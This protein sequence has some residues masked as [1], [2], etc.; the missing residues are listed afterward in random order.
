MFVLIFNQLLKMLFIMLLAVICFKIGLINQ[1]GNR[2]L[3]NLLLMVINPCVILTVYQTD[4]D[5]R[6]ARGLLISFAAAFAAHIIAIAVARL[7]IPSKNNEN[8]AIDRF[9]AVYSNCGFIGIPLINSVL[10]SEGVF[11]LTAY[12]TVFNL[13]AWTHGLTLLS[14]KFELKRLK[15][16]LLSPMVVASL[17]AVVLFFVQLRIPGVILDSMEY[18][19]DMNTPVAMLVAGFSLAQTDIRKI[20]T[21]LRI[22]WV[23]IVKLLLVPLAV[24]VFLWVLKLDYTV[25]YTTLIAAACPTSATTTM[26]CIR[27]NHNYKYASEIFSFTTVLSIITIPLVTLA[28]SFLL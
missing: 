7:M 1:E 14:R 11:Y 6:L 28:A 20:M 19:A 3:S 27:F 22:Y 12:M 21:N 13:L 23:S 10:G 26:L 9:A 15:E 5:P 18:V 16:G 2:N 4:Y 25:A 8:Y 24:L 17:I